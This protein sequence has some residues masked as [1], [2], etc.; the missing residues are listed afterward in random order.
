MS[1]VK[2][3]DS[4]FQALSWQPSPKN[5]RNLVAT[6]TAIDKIFSTW[7]RKNLW[8]QIKPDI[9]WALLL[10]RALPD[11]N[12]NDIRQKVLKDVMIFVKKIDEKEIES[13]TALSNTPIFD[14]VKAELKLIM[15]GSNA[16]KLSSSTESNSTHNSSKK[17]GGGFQ[18]SRPYVSKSGY[19]IQNGNVESAAVADEAMTVT[20]NGKLF[21]GEVYDQKTMISL[22][23]Y[24]TRPARNVP[25]FAVKKL[26]TM[27]RQCFNSDNSRIATSTCPSAKSHYV[28]QCTSCKMYGHHSSN[29]LQKSA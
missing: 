12:E 28:T 19:G 2:F 24:K 14:K 10:L 13:E 6:V 11:E 23:A 29:C 9:F 3:A 26:S 18:I 17:F 16:F 25:Y 22:P 1:F 5:A 7:N 15:E 27:C 21:S 20:D 4:L 8:D